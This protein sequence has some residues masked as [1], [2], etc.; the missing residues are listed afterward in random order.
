MRCRPV[1]GP[2]ASCRRCGGW[3]APG[4]TGSRMATPLPHP[5][6]GALRHRAGG[7]SCGPTV[8][9]ALERRRPPWACAWRRGVN[10]RRASGPVSRRRVRAEVRPAAGG[11][12][13]STVADSGCQPGVRLIARTTLCTVRPPPGPAL[14]VG[15][16]GDRVPGRRRAPITDR[17]VVSC[18]RRLTTYAT[19]STR[20]PDPAAG[21]ARAG[22]P[23]P[24]APV[25]AGPR[26][27]PG[28][29]GAM[30]PRP[31]RGARRA[32]TGD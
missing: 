7:Q 32:A 19:P 22:R 12:T 27:P 3:S 20:G 1:A 30:R 17:K 11:P 28:A 16:G 18:S 5:G 2:G 25:P 26:T 23:E 21:V 8:D 10:P 29:S 4:R 15:T 9:A 31:A 14:V 13:D 24:S 6:R